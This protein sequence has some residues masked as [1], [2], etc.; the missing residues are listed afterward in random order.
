MG[1]PVFT[2]MIIGAGVG[3]MMDKDQP[4]RGAALGGALGYGGSAVMGAGGVASSPN[5]YGA[6]MNSTMPAGAIDGVAAATGP[7]SQYATLAAQDAAFG[8][9]ALVS[10]IGQVATGPGSQAAMLAG[11]GGDFGTSGL[12]STGD[13]MNAPGMTGKMYQA[14]NNLAFG[15]Q[16]STD[17]MKAGQAM[18]SMGQR[19]P[20]P[21]MPPAPIVAAPMNRPQPLPFNSPYERQ[22][23]SYTYGQPSLLPGFRG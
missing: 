16:N 23:Q 14:G 6:M 3:A 4:L 11:N 20:Q 8:P 22:P 7:G 10:K 1:D 13:A 15:G 18:S 9:S 17:I 21:Q 19:E 5:A 12:L 2:P